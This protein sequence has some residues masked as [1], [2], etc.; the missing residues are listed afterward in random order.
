MNRSYF[1]YTLL[2]CTLWFVSCNPS[3]KKDQNTSLTEKR[4]ALDQ[5]EEIQQ[6]SDII[7]RFAAAYLVQ[8]SAKTNAFIHPE[9]VLAII[10]RPGVMD[11]FT[12]VDH[13]DFNNPIPNYYPYI[14]FEHHSTLR[15]EALPEFD[16]GP[17]EWD[18]EGFF[19]DTTSA[20]TTNLLQTILDF[21]E[22]YGEASFSS[23]TREQITRLE[24]GSF[25]V[26]LNPP[27]GNFLIFH[28]KKFDTGWYVTLIDRAYAG[29][30]A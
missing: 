1:G 26:I 16:C 30:D 13:I 9:E 28:V 20:N 19:C 27:N 15:F 11:V 8:D 3:S 5:P 25:R 14:A 24:A 6:I 12:L 23:E 29:C 4:L 22:E 17:M 2:L 21:Q 7:T 18:K 10:H